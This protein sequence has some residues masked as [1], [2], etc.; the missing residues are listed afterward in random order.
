[1][2]QR[3]CKTGLWAYSRHPNYL[4]E[5][6]CWAGIYLIACSVESGWITVWSP[7]LIFLLVR[8]VSGVPT[9]EGLYKD[10]PEFQQWCSTTNVFLLMPPKKGA[11]SASLGDMK[12]PGGEV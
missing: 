7:V 10:D 5:S 12:A 9:V 1:M 2:G 8:F 4:G 6:L 11:E 3:L